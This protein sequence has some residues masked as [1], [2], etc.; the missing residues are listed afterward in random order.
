MER[1]GGNRIHPAGVVR[2]D[3]RAGAR[4]AGA[5]TG[6]RRRTGRRIL[7]RRLRKCCD[8]GVAVPRNKR[9]RGTTRRP[10]DAGNTN[11]VSDLL[12]G[13]LFRNAR[14][15]LARC[16]SSHGA[17]CGPGQGWSG[18]PRVW[19][20]TA[21]VRPM[22]DGWPSGVDRRGIGAVDHRAGQHPC[23]RD[24]CLGAKQRGRRDPR[25]GNGIPDSQRAGGQRRERRIAG[26]VPGAR[27]VCAQ[28]ARRISAARPPVPHGA[29]APSAAA[30]GTAA[31]RAHRA[32]SGREHDA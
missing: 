27:L 2:R 24:L 30:T 11:P 5:S 17:G 12:P 31:G 6:V 8:P 7:G 22:R 18:R 23:R 13:E 21:V 16:P 10:V 1:S 20:R 26:P 9:W 29:R 15:P 28:P 25:S 19:H 4:I 3:R 32:L 14:A